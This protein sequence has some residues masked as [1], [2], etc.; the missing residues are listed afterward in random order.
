MASANP[1]EAVQEGKDSG[2]P[3]AVAQ[4]STIKVSLQPAAIFVP[5]KNDEDLLSRED[6][7]RETRGGFTRRWLDAQRVAQPD[8]GQ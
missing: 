2:I 4:P 6:I 8:A 7:E 1:E 3:S 5:A